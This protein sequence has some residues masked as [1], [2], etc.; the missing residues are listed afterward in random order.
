[1]SY[2][3]PTDGVQSV[4]DDHHGTPV[5]PLPD[6]DGLLSGLADRSAYPV[7]PLRGRDDPHATL[8]IDP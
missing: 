6:P 5:G 7:A 2:R 8:A 3:C 4:V 1:M